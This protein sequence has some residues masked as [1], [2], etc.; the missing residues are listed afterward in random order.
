[1][2]GNI[3]R[4]KLR[5]QLGK[6]AMG[7]VCL[8][9]D[10]V[11]NRQ[12]A[13][14]TIDLAIEDPEKREF[15]RGRLLR[16]ARAAAALTHPNIVSVY[17]VVEDG[18]IAAIIMEFV[19][20]ENLSAYLLREGAG[21]MAFTRQVIRAMAAALDYTHSRGVIHRGIK[22]A[23]VMLDGA[24]TPKITDFGIARITEGVTTTMT[25]AVMGTIEYMAPE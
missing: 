6:G 22:P 17:D 13:V 14:K 1:M 20:G 15:L 9:D 25:G 21:D 18:D 5:G 19:D 11:L 10:P 24:R 4:Y 7:V 12:V 16:D 23:N 2:L 8:A 3:G